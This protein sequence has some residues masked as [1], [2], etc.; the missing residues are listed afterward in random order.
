M[1]DQIKKELVIFDFEQEQ[2]KLLKLISHNPN[3]KIY[4]KLGLFISAAITTSLLFTASN[5]L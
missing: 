5:C 4:Q 3:E 1:K 2:R